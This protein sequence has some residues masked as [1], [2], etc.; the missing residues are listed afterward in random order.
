LEEW[1]AVFYLLLE[2]LPVVPSLAEV[3]RLQPLKLTRLIDLLFLQL[4]QVMQ[5]KEICNLPQHKL[6]PNLLQ[7]ERQKNPGLILIDL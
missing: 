5:S 6:H 4:T 7:L 2:G 3:L 1:Q